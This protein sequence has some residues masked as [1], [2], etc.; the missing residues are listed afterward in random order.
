MYDPHAN[1]SPFNSVPPAALVIAGLIAA[2]E[3]V[4]QAGSLGF[5][6][7]PTSIGWRLDAAQNYGFSSLLWNRMWEAGQFPPQFLMQIVTYPFIHGSFL[8][9]AF[10][11]VIVLAIGKAVGEIF[12]PWAFL[13]VFFGASIGGALVF[14]L[15]TA[16]NVVLIGAYPGGYGLIGAFTF[17]LWVQLAAMGENEMRA[18][19]LIGVLMG[20]QLVFGAIFGT[21]PDWIADLAGFILGFGLSFLVSPGGWQRVLAKLRQR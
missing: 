11:C 18:F 4:F 6:G 19:T 3:L 9:A 1:A 15:L 17:I 14:A 13:I 5:A 8:H 21:G 20:I 16:T 10:A 12:S 2:I 7:G